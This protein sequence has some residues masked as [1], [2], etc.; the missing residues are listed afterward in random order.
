MYF[1]W[2]AGGG[3]GE[4]CFGLRLGFSERQPE[5]QSI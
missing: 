2:F 5:I 1:N 3:C 4:V